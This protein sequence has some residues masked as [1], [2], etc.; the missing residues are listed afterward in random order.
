MKKVFL[1]LFTL[2]LGGNIF[3]DDSTQDIN[4]PE[5]LSRVLASQEYADALQVAR[6]ALPENSRDEL[7][8]SGIS[9]KKDA[10]LL[11]LVIINLE[12][13]IVSIEP[14]DGVTVSRIDHGQLHGMFSQTRSGLRLSEVFYIPSK[15]SANDNKPSTESSLKLCSDESMNL[16]TVDIGYKCQTSRGAIY[17]RV[18]Q[19]KFGEAWQG[20]DGL[21]WSDTIGQYTNTGEISGDIVVDSGATRGCK[22]IGGTLP[23]VADFQRGEFNGFREVL[24]NM[25]FRGDLYVSYWTAS[26]AHT[27]YG[28]DA[29]VFLPF[30][31]NFIPDF[32]RSYE[33]VRCVTR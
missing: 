29:Y 19:D 26:V 21:I 28:S 31:G 23:E 9:V 7:V 15:K 25:E 16:R 22:N 14:G 13:V 5:E 4:F 30:S 3:A 1:I 33:Y 2:T 20:P 17:E 32:R 6:N 18:A 10:S 27:Q 11:P 24:P 12:Q 8:L